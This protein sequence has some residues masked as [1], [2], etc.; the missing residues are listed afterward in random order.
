MTQGASDLLARFRP[1]VLG[2]L[3]AAMLACLLFPG[4]EPP[5]NDL[6]WRPT[7]PGLLFR[8]LSQAFSDRPIVSKTGELSFEI[9]L[10]PGFV[11]STAN[12]EIFSFYGDRGLRPLLLGQFPNG[13]MLHGPADNPSGD[14][15]YDQYLDLDSV[16]LHDPT[17]LRHLAVSVASEGARLHVNGRATSLRLANTV[18]RP[19]QDFGGRVLLGNS[20]TG[21]GEW[22]GG[23]LAVAIHQRVLDSSELLVH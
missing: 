11:P 14:P 15:R 20:N 6:A 4:D 1:G 12:Q 5:A 9:W 22:H 2:L 18:A 23:M 8:G 16:G 10:D 13:F 17:A 21:W 3:V 7:G 19:G